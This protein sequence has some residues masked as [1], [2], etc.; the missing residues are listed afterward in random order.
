MSRISAGRLGRRGGHGRAFHAEPFHALV[1]HRSAGDCAAF[2]V[3]NLKRFQRSASAFRWGSQYTHF[4]Y[5]VEASAPF[6]L[7]ATSNEFCLGAAANDTDCGA[8]GPNVVM[9]CVAFSPHC[10]VPGHGGA[11]RY[12]WLHPGES[13]QFVSGLALNADGDFVLSYGVNDCEARV[14]V[15]GRERVWRSL[16]PM[17]LMAGEFA[18]CRGSTRDGSDGI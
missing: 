11:A 5:A 14:G 1:R 2:T 3:C 18:K 9:A 6:R 13:V 12:S 4:F 7:L 15:V 10:Q 17:P 8:A 16:Q